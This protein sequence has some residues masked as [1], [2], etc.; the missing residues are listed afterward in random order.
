VSMIEP[1]DFATGFAA[2]RRMTAASVASSPYHGPCTRAI[3]R[4]AR[5]EQANG[6]LSPVVR[7]VRTILSTRRP[8]LRYPRATAVQRAFVAV[9]PF[10]PHALAEFLVRD[11]YGLN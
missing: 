11:A 7:A 5:V 9:R 10:L 4:M 2:N 3:A 8:A 1:G 6:D